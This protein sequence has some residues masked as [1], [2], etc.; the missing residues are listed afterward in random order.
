MARPPYRE[1]SGFS[2]FLS[3]TV[4][5]L[6]IIIWSILPNYPQ[7]E[8][9]SISP[10]VF[11]LQNLN[12]LWAWS[13]YQYIHFI[14]EVMELLPQRY[15]IT[16]VQCLILMGM[17]FIYLGLLAYNEDVLTVPLDDMRTLT[18]DKADIVKFKDH[19]EFLEKFAFRETSG[20]LDLPITKV[21]EVLYT[22]EK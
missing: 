10:P 5:L 18:D 7:Y 8:H 4:I 15:W 21:C 22:R 6:F 2:Q 9:Q 14:S 13:K 1:Y 16:C 3:S 19:T 12:E 11:P 20:V 17:L